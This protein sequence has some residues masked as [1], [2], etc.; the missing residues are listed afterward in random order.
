MGSPYE[1]SSSSTLPKAYPVPSP[2][3]GE[4]SNALKSS[5][6]VVNRA[7]RKEFWAVRAVTGGTLEETVEEEEEIGTRRE[8]E[9][10]VSVVEREEGWEDMEVIATGIGLG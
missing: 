8:E 6:V 5:S 7:R 10:D 9:E 3:P 1:C 4:G 2:S